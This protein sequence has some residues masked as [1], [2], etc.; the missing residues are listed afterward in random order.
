M[1]KKIII[2][3]MLIMLMLTFSSCGKGKKKKETQSPPFDGGTIS[4]EDY[5]A[6]LSEEKTEH[7]KEQT[8]LLMHPLKDAIEIYGEDYEFTWEGVY[9]TLTYPEEGCSFE[10]YVGA[11][12]EAYPDYENCNVMEYLSFAAIE[13]VMFDGEG[14]TLT[15][16]IAVGMTVEDITKILNVD[17]I[18]Y[19]ESTT[20]ITQDYDE[21]GNKVDVYS[22]CTQIER[23]D[24]VIVFKGDVLSQ[25]DVTSVSRY[26]ADGQE[27]SDNGKEVLDKAFAYLNE[28]KLATFD[29]K[30][31]T[32]K[33]RIYSSHYDSW[34]DSWKFTQGDYKD[35]EINVEE[36]SPNRIYVVSSTDVLPILFWKDG[37]YVEPILSFLGKW[38]EH[39]GKEYIDIK[40]ISKEGVVVFDLNVRVGDA[41]EMF[42]VKNVNAVL[43]DMPATLDA[44]FQAEYMDEYLR[45]DVQL[46]DGNI[47]SGYYG[48][49]GDKIY[50]MDLIILNL[51]GTIEYLSR[52]M[53]SGIGTSELFVHIPNKNH[54]Y[55]QASTWGYME[56]FGRDDLNS[57]NII[58]NQS[59]GG[60]TVINNYLNKE[61]ETSGLNYSQIEY[62]Y[63]YD[64]VFPVN[65]VTYHVWES[66]DT[67]SPHYLYVDSANNML[68]KETQISM[69]SKHSKE[70]IYKSNTKVDVRSFV[71][72]KFTTLDGKIKIDLEKRTITNPDAFVPNITISDM[73]FDSVSQNARFMFFSEIGER[74]A[75]NG[76]VLV[77]FTTWGAS[78]HI[79]D[80]NIPGFEIGVYYLDIQTFFLDPSIG[81]VG[82]PEKSESDKYLDDKL[83]DAGKETKL[84]IR[85]F[86]GEIIG[87]VYVDEKGNK[88]VKNFYGKILGY[89]YVDRD[90]TT[91]FQ[92]RI[93]ARGD[94][95][96]SLLFQE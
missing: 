19:S 41:G 61:Y 42:L 13:R 89:Y 66:L 6:S 73:G 76:Y 10:V 58:K 29:A 16:G 54:D 11:E 25:V 69:I 53:G 64:Y 83:D 27:D 14:K 35:Y 62:K 4:I 88:T 28:N 87:Y 50:L 15:D 48:Y 44:Y 63:L 24:C 49:M 77:N 92:G 18:E 17:G 80:S 70:L 52:S 84:V 20:Y 45:G 34:F 23:V 95:A 78:L 59:P 85:K 96:S 65:N 12:F 57:G 5:M 22:I 1:L 37:K 40:S 71:N 47:Q 94:A 8:S 86:S 46:F 81:V 7:L 68:I 74:F 33:G 75:L 3:T 2:T 82:V 56:N 31:I 36:G 72:Q 91:D 55:T 90:V 60:N 32:Y 38:R 30:D 43:D 79:T 9:V 67:E 21:N 26:L 93:Y 51:S 39:D